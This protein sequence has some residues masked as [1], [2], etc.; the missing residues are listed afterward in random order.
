MEYIFIHAKKDLSTEKNDGIR[1]QI[2]KKEIKCK[3]VAF[4]RSFNEFA[5][6]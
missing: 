6:L 4:W 5:Y 3:K 1:I 2:K